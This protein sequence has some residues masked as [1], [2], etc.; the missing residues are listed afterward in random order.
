MATVVVLMGR[1]RAE[2]LWLA[3]PVLLS[4]AVTAI[5][6]YLILAGASRVDRVL[7]RTGLNILERVAGLLLAAIAIQFV[8]DGI[9]EAMPGIVRGLS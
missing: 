5:L 4:I 3:A 9:A 6:S 8:I 7:G 1:A 2:H